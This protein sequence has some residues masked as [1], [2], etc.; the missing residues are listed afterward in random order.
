MGADRPKREVSGAVSH[1]RCQSLEQFAGTTY[2]ANSEQYAYT[3][4]WDADKTFGCVCDWPYM[5]HDCAQKE[6][7]VGAGYRN[8]MMVREPKKL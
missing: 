7:P 8:W 1:G 6:C 2:N 4:V 5:G 3:G